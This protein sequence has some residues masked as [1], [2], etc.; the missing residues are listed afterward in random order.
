MLLR[1]P[2]RVAFACSRMVIPSLDH[3]VVA[4]ANEE[5]TRRNEVRGIIVMESSRRKQLLL[6]KTWSRFGAS[7]MYLSPAHHGVA[8]GARISRW[9]D[10]AAVLSRRTRDERNQE[11]D[12][13]GKESHVRVPT[14]CSS[15]PP[16]THVAV[17]V[18]VHDR[19]V[20]ACVDQHQ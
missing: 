19:L 8:Q 3:A 18:H 4:P 14:T 1:S 11:K 20:V 15:S 7:D 5:L 12:A 10:Q 13:S 6:D 17:V 9:V 2:V 16:A